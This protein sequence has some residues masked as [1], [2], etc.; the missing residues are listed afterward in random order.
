MTKD[1]L[2]INPTLLDRFIDWILRHEHSAEEKALYREE[3]RKLKL[4]N[5]REE[6]K[7]AA[8]NG[9][10]DT[11]FTVATYK[12]PITVGNRDCFSLV[13]LQKNNAGFRKIVVKHSVRKSDGHPVAVLPNDVFKLLEV[14][15]LYITKL[16]PWYDGLHEDKKLK[17]VFDKNF[18]CHL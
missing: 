5:D 2:D 6:A 17:E 3:I 11:F 18:V 1:D 9:K 8:E 7:Q 10:S 14:T 4:E 16:R 15:T 13:L 12:F